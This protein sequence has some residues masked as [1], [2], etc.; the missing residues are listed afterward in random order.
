MCMPDLNLFRIRFVELLKFDKQL[1][2]LHSLL[3]LS[4]LSISRNYANFFLWL[5]FILVELVEEIFE[6]FV[7]K[8]FTEPFK[9]SVQVDIFKGLTD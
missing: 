3:F 9:L 4:W 8:M 2:I 7:L 6:D 5:R 1:E